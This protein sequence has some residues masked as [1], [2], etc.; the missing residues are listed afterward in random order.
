[1]ENQSAK[2]SVEGPLFAASQS[3]DRG[4]SAALRDDLDVVTLA[5]EPND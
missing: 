3:K 1:M 2:V 4:I 5:A